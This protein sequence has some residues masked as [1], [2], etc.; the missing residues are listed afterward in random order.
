MRKQIAVAWTLSALV[1]GLSVALTQAQQ[2]APPTSPPRAT[3]RA[4]NTPP[5]GF[6]ALFNGQDLAGWKGLVADPPKRAKMTPEEL[7]RAQQVADKSTREHWA[8]QDGVLVFDGKGENLCTARD[9]GDFELFVDWRIE[10]G[11]DS[12]IYLRG[13]PQVQIWDNPLGSGGLYNNQKHASNPLFV[14]D[15]PL[16]DEKSPGAWNTFRILMRGERVTVYLNDILV[17][18]DTPLENY[19]ERDKSIYASGAIELQNHGGPLWFRNIYVREL[20]SAAGGDAAIEPRTQV[21][22]QASQPAAGLLQ[23]GDRVAIVG[24][25]ITEQKLYSRFIE[26]YLTA[27]LPQLDIVTCQFGWGGEW[28]RG[29][30]ARM[31]NDLL[32]WKPTVVTTC[33]GMNDGGYKPY[34]PEIGQVYA[35]AMRGIAERLGQT[36]CG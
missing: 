7:A 36:A 11:G 19:W 24:D 32:P 13:S 25:S 10:K 27:C 29:F 4:P 28:A 3:P 12:G 30:A 18:D 23:R 22:G 15:K 21:R 6:T 14:A 1:F 20:P 2:A 35:D 8:V 33:Y 34:A 9:F 31:D 16:G 26:D 17:V 5:P